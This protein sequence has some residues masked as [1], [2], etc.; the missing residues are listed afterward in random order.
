MKDRLRGWS[1]WFIAL[2]AI[3][4]LYGCGG[5]AR[6]LRGEGEAPPQA[7]D[8]VRIARSQLGAPYRPGGV[9]PSTGFDCSGFTSWVYGQEGIVIPRRSLDQFG[10]GRE[11]P[12][13]ELRAGDLVFFEI[14][15]RGPSHV[16]I[17]TGNGEFIHCPSSGGV[18]REESI[19]MDYWVRCYLGA[20][21][22]IP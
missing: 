20:R 17:Y 2:L 16:G 22:V 21:R 3:S 9:S 15:Q 5:G 4:A 14:Y 11:A 10:A 18:V 13:D 6:T 8:I 1:S 7:K 12:R 19:F